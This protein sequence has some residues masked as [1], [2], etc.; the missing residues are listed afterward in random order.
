MDFHGDLDCL[1][2]RNYLTQ[3]RPL[4]PNFVRTS[5]KFRPNFVQ[6][7]S[8]FVTLRHTSSLGRDIPWNIPLTDIP[9][10]YGS[11]F[12]IKFIF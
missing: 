7:S 9:L 10:G 11:N 2:I 12:Q 1:F 4:S 3:L 5:S 8:H 6:T